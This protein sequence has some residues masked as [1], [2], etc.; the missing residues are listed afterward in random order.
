MNYASAP[1][2]LLAA[3]WHQ[4]FLEWEKISKAAAQ[5][6]VPP[7]FIVVCRDT[8]VAQRSPFVAG[9]RQ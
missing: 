6:P 7:V 8:A 4:R 2:N 1:I 5:H 9:Q 3:E